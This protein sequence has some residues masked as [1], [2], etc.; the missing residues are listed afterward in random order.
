MYTAEIESSNPLQGAAAGAI[1]GLLGSAAMVLINRVLAAT[2]QKAAAGSIFHYGF[3][4]VAG[5][6]YGALAA[7]DPKVTKGGGV[8]F[9]AAVFLT[10][11][12]RGI[13]RL[14]THLVYGVT[15]EAVRRLLMRR[16]ARPVYD[17][18]SL[19]V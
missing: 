12:E 11:G 17:L 5:A 9:G 13:P 2:G 3:G 19:G 4:A 14:A 8:P 1:G 7:T 10:A 15:L 16:R 18:S 6:V